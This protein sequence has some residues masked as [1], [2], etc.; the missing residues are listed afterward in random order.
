MGMPIKG[1]AAVGKSTPTGPRKDGPP[2]SSRGGILSATAQREILRKA[3]ATDLTM[4]EA[5]TSA[6]KGGLV[7]LKVTGWT[8]SKASDKADRGVS[9]LI[10]WLE[11]KGSIRLG[12][13]ARSLRIKKVCCRQ[14]AD[15][16]ISF[17][18]HATTSGPPSFAA[19]LRTRT[20]IHVYGQRLPY[21]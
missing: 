6:A 15:R 10:S 21:G 1:R 12:S 9:S 11:K 3:G 16:H 18:Q 8:K 14:H 2:R 7:E 13:R 20:A 5:R 4:K 19:N 17:C